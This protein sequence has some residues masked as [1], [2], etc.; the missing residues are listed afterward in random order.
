MLGFGILLALD[1]LGRVVATGPGPYTLAL[2]GVLFVAAWAYLQ[3]V[4][5][6]IR[7]HRARGGGSDGNG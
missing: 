3:T 1:A 6:L 2:T 5:T 7:H 4:N